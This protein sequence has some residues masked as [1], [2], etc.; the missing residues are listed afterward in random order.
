VEE[1]AP[2]KLAK[3]GRDDEL[4]ATLRDLAEGLRVLAMLLHSFM[5]GTALAILERLGLPASPDEARESEIFAW[6]ACA[7]GKLEPGTTVVQGP[8]LFPRIED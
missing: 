3:E 5:P 8:P 1:Q 2:W 6:D 7:W 4:D